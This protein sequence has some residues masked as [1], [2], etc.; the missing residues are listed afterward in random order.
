MTR[1]K[2]CGM[3]GS[4]NS[5]QN[6]IDHRHDA[7]ASVILRYLNALVLDESQARD[8]RLKE[9]MARASVAEGLRIVSF[10]EY[11]GVTID[12]LDECSL[13]HT[14][15]LKSIDGC[16]TA[17]SCLN[18]GIERIVFE[19]GGNTGAALAAYASGSESSRSV[20]CRKTIC[21]FSTV[22]FLFTADPSGRRRRCCR[23]ARTGLAP[24]RNLR[25]H[26]GAQSSVAAISI[27]IRRMLHHRAD[28]H[29]TKV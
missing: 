15:T 25:A 28:H 10:D 7:S 9:L 19:S 2:L 3:S 13:M 14:R 5:F 26:T 6:A 24:G 12:I 29:W 22:R 8:A 20:S 1:A 21:R 16:V 11:R 23:A 17:A 4:L 27:G 18:Q